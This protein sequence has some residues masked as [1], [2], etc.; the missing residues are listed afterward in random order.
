MT[1]SA[2]DK[3]PDVLVVD[4][5]MMLRLYASDLL[6]EK[7]FSVIE[8][9]NADEA[10]KRLEEYPG[11]RL[12][13]TDVNMPGELDGLDLAHEVHRRWPHV[14][15]VVTSGKAELGSADLPD[16]GRF[17]PKPYDEEALIAEVKG[18]IEQHPERAGEPPDEMQ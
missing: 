4:D 3:K 7:G 14:L 8:A 1:E 10:L 18:L 9:S 2:D 6:E 13:F 5:E 17:I 12:L 16:D 15:L 11:I